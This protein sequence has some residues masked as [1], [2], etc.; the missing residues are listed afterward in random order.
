MNERS[1]RNFRSRRTIIAAVALAVVP[2]GCDKLGG[3]K[4]DLA[5]PRSGEPSRPDGNL[6][7]ASSASAVFAVSA[8]PAS[9]APPVDANDG[10]RV[11]RFAWRPPGGSA[12]AY[13]MDE[14]DD[15]HRIVIVP[16]VA[17][18]A[19]YPVLIA[20]HGQPRRGE[21]PRHYA[22]AA[23]VIETATRAV[24]RGDVA[25]MILVVP[26]F[27]YFGT[28]WPGFDV[29]AFRNEVEERL[30]GE[31]VRTGGYY[32][33]GH[34]GAAG[35][36]G[37]GMNRVHRMRP[38][39]VGFF[40]TC[41]GRGWREE[42]RLLREARIPTLMIH[43]LE[44]AAFWPRQPIE[45]SPTFDF[46]R[47]DG[48]AGLSAVACPGELP[49]APLRAQAYRCSADQQGITKGFIVDTGEG[50]EGHNAVVPVAL[51]YFLKQYVTR[52]ADHRSS[53]AAP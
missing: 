25:P 26:V 46:G 19:T 50:E 18:G 41:L 16:K 4:G 21:A 35:C 1:S 8:Q 38:Q 10:V 52:A 5:L 40:D 31:G 20:F 48:P 15:Q 28:N 43:S 2:L 49:R 17:P 14:P 24:E 36:G 39:A 23:R 51:E 47:A 53:P 9:S 6:A 7:A 3:R 27:R 44:T 33:V 37:D 45:Y 13:A 42:V 32:V 11:V 22:F 34:S 12:E 29:L 30:A